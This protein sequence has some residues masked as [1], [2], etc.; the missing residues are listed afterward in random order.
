MEK[1]EKMEMEKEKRGHIAQTKLGITVDE[2]EVYSTP[3][4]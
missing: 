2:L 4:R 3:S 1:E